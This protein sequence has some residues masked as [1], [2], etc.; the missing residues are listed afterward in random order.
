[1]CGGVVGVHLADDEGDVGLHAPLRG[2]VD[3]DRAPFGGLRR[4][5]ARD[6]G[7]GREQRDVDAFEGVRG[8]LLHRP[9]STGELHGA[10]I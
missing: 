6:P 10:A 2:V 9:L 4:Q 1:M 7:S 8:R 5:V 3:H